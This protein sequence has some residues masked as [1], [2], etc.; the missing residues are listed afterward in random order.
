MFSKT[1]ISKTANIVILD[2][3]VDFN[4]GARQNE[5]VG[6]FLEMLPTSKLIVESS[7]T[8][9]AGAH[10][11]IGESSSLKIGGGFINRHIKIRCFHSIDIG[12][13]VAISENV[14]IWDTD[15]HEI[16]R[17]NYHKSAPVRIGNRVWI[18]AN[19]T[20]LK[21]VHIGDNSIIG[22]GSVVNKDI[23]PNCLAV[24]NP[25]KVVRTDIAWR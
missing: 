4:C 23:P 17:K 7:L 5:P 8:I 21:G 18:G 1:V 2:G 22:A 24:G 16:I 11:I 12:N 3:S 19:V 14:M 15:A 10:I 13:N 20:I 6:G 25:A 9:Y